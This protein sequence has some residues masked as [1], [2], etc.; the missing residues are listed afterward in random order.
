MCG[1]GGAVHLFLI[2]PLPPPAPPRICVG[3]GAVLAPQYCGPVPRAGTPLM[4]KVLEPI[5]PTVASIQSP[6]PAPAGP[7]TRRLFWVRGWVV[8]RIS[9]TSP[10]RPLSKAGSEVPPMPNA[11][12][13]RKLLRDTCH[14]THFGIL[15][16]IFFMLRKHR[17]CVEVRVVTAVK[18]ELALILGTSGQPLCFFCRPELRVRICKFFRDKARFKKSKM[19]HKNMQ[20]NIKSSDT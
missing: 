19:N 10:P 12:A 8:E 2:F 7:S 16:F 9:K 20:K 17:G 11:Q 15:P 5:P 1:E 18:K 6:D 4:S 14:M 13:T 3:G